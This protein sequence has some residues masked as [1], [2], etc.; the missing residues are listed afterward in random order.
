MFDLDETLRVVFYYL[1]VN[2]DHG[3]HGSGG[4]R[5][6]LGVAASMRV[7]SKVK[8]DWVFFKNGWFRAKIAKV[9]AQTVSF[10]YHKNNLKKTHL[11]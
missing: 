2:H 11:S 5:G 8:I 1:L 10:L 4:Y 3:D 7:I 9:G 6:V